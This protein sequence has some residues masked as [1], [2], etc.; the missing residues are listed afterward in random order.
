M[1]PQPAWLARPGR[2]DRPGPRH[3]RP[4]PRRRALRRLFQFTEQVEAEG[5]GRKKVSAEPLFVQRLS[6][7]VVTSIVALRLAL[8]AGPVRLGAQL[9]LPASTVGAVLRREQLPRLAE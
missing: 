2:S 3:G 8:H 4:A 7:L 9:R 6:L 1:P 5:H